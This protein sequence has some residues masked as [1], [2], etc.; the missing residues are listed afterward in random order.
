M[1]NDKKHEYK[2]YTEAQ[3]DAGNAKRIVL[4]GSHECTKDDTPKAKRKQ[5]HHH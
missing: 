5:Q 4:H 2:N 3:N 1:I